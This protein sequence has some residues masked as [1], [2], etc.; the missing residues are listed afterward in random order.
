MKKT[1]IVV[2]SA[3][4]LTACASS[5]ESVPASASADLQATATQTCAQA[6]AAHHITSIFLDGGAVDWPNE[7]PLPGTTVCVENRDGSNKHCTPTDA[8]G[9]ASLEVPPCTDVRVTYTL[10]GYLSINQL[11]R[12]TTTSAPIYTRML[13]I[14][15]M[16]HSGDVLG[17]P[18][19]PTKAYP[20]TTMWTP[21]GTDPLAGVSLHLS[22]AS[23]T[24]FYLD[25]SGNPT[26]ALH[27]TEANG[28]AAVANASAGSA[29]EMTATAPGKTC[30]PQFA[31]P[32]T[33]PNSAV[34][35]LM[36]SSIGE[37]LF[38]CE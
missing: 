19:D 11:F 4:A 2:A 12:I 13:T 37:A 14:A 15:Q 22:P 24:V 23:G 29:T 27:A 38:F 7:N 35:E 30:K 33:A 32:G 25:D 10:A 21:P 9:N 8:K 31:V 34:V 18:F 17:I 26:T 28:I 5:G 6:A 3:I 20:V 16:Q 1:G 36:P